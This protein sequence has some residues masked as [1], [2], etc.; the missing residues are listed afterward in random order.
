MGSQLRRGKAPGRFRR[1]ALPMKKC[2]S[3]QIPVLFLFRF[4]RRICS[5]LQ[6][7]VL[8]YNNESAV[9]NLTLVS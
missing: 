7:F 2:V 3:T 9:R 1:G 8:T 5:R 4:A 6:H